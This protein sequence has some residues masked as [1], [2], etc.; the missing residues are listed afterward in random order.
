M[1]KTRITVTLDHDIAEWIELAS[2]SIN[3]SQSE[4]IRICLHEYMDENA[5]RFS[6]SNKARSKSEDTWLAEKK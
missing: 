3:R 4:I 6:R 2:I 5:K 1:K